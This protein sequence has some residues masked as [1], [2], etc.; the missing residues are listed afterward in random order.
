[1]TLRLL[2]TCIALIAPAIAQTPRKTVFIDPSSRW[3][4]LHDTN[5]SGT[6]TEL[7]IYFEKSCKAIWV[8]RDAGKADYTVALYR[9]AGGG[10]A[11]VYAGDR[12]AFTFK[13]GFGAK[14]TQAA[15]K[16]CFWITTDIASAK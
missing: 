16:A 8:A 3:E 4:S 1:V 14:L 2:L 13:P 15:D 10:S 11:V 7:A 6:P 12:V 5:G 9:K